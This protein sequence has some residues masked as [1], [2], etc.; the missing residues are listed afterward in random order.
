M[1]MQKL[2]NQDP[3]KIAQQQLYTPTCALTPTSSGS[4][5][6]IRSITRRAVQALELG[7]QC[8]DHRASHTTSFTHI[9]NFQT[10]A[11]P[12]VGGRANSTGSL[13]VSSTRVGASAS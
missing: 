1:Q 4:S 3:L 5:R 2:F 13:K 6:H 10:T 8:A 12:T 9:P 11:S 7:R